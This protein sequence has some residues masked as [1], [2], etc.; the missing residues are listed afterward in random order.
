MTSCI[1]PSLSSLSSFYSYLSIRDR[2]DEIPPLMAVLRFVVT[3]VY[4]QFCYRTYLLSTRVSVFLYFFSPQLVQVVLYCNSKLLFSPSLAIGLAG[5]A[6]FVRERP[7]VSCG[8]FS[9]AHQER[10]LRGAVCQEADCQMPADKIGKL[11]SKIK[12]M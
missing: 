1:A 6:T 10:Q 4:W 7:T 2:S 11:S 12:R 5:S 9:D 3:A 8:G